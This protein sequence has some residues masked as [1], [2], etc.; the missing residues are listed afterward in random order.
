MIEAEARAEFEAVNHQLREIQAM[1][2]H[3]NDAW[4]RTVEKRIALAH[5]LREFE[6]ARARE[7]SAPG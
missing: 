2:A 7:L 5:V 3:Y 4:V 1:L 6:L